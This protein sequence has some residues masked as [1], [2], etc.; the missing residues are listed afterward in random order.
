M[1]AAPPPGYA[2]RKS[3]FARPLSPPPRVVAN[4]YVATAAGTGEACSAFTDRASRTRGDESLRSISGDVVGR[5]RRSAGRPTR[6][7]T[8]RTYNPGAGTGLQIAQCVPRGDLSSTPAP[9]ERAQR[10]F[11]RKLR[12]LGVPAA[13]HARGDV[14]TPRDLHPEAVEAERPWPHGCGVVAGFAKAI[15]G[16]ARTATRTHRRLPLR[17]ST[18]R[19]DARSRVRPAIQRQLTLVSSQCLFSQCLGHLLLPSLSTPNLPTS[20]FQPVVSIW[21]LEFGS[22]EFR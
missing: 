7:R 21:R 2:C 18:R 9:G 19:L 5:L 20:N 13:S 11:E 15:A 16:L 17:R 1:S 22:W 10:G 12:L 4:A 8:W 6:P 3:L 14:L